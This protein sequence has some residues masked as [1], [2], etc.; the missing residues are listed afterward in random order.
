MIILSIKTDQEISEAGLFNRGNKLE[1]VKWQAHRELSS[2]IHKKIEGILKSQNISWN[3]I[4]GVVFFEG[5]GSFTG[6]RIGASVA[7]ALASDLDIPIV[8]TAGSKWIENGIK[9]LANNPENRLAVP[10]Y[11]SSIHITKPRK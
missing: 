10:K 3:N 8:Q 2:T 4:Q 9:Q 7:N 11:G 6:L 5:P 1:Y